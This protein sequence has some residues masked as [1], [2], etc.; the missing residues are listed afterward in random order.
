MTGLL[1]ML[2]QTWLSTFV[3]ESPSFFGYPTFLFAHT[4]GLSV[5]VGISTVVAARMLGIASGIPLAPLVRLFPLMW[6]GFI[7]NLISGGGL[8]LADA[9]NKTIP[10]NGNQAPIF[11]TK[12]LFVIVGAI[13]LWQMQKRLT[14]PD[15]VTGRPSPALRMI[16]ASLLIS[17][18]LAMIAGRLI[19]YTSAIL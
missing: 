18:V 15:A 3:R 1:T 16:S 2:E 12:M 13:L 17:W 9:V 5:V 14:G 10:G 7:V 8:W 6:A 4:F 19:G 11:M